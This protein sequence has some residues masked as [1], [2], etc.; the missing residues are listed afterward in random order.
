MPIDCGFDDRAQGKPEL[1]S[2]TNPGKPS[3][4]TVCWRPDSRLAA[5]TSWSNTPAF[6]NALAVDSSPTSSTAHF[7]H[8]KSRSVAL[9]RVIQSSHPGRQ[10][11][12][13]HQRDGFLMPVK[14]G[15]KP[16]DTRYFERAGK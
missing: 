12:L 5:L 3:L 4:G 2:P 11:K 14:K 7:Y 16:A 6:H 9:A 10:R 1:S 8:A 15:Q 13:L